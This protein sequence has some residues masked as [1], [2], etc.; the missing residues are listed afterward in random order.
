MYVSIA[1][2]VLLNQRLPPLRQKDGG[3]KER[4]RRRVSSRSTTAGLNKLADGLSPPQGEAWR[5]S[6][7]EL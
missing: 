5:A 2:R 1:I 3:H 6:I 7:G 4:E